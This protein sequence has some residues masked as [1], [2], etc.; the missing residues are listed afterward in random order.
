MIPA[1]VRAAALNDITPAEGS[2]PARAKLQK[3]AVPHAAANGL[4][5]SGHDDL[6]L[7]TS[8][9]DLYRPSWTEFASGGN[10]AGPVAVPVAVQGRP[11]QSNLVRPYPLNCGELS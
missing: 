4:A 5:S 3:V 9:N 10:E 8:A 7:P 2:A 11:E 1:I 6:Q